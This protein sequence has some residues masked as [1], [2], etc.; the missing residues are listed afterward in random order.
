MA[1]PL[2]PASC[3]PLGRGCALSRRTDVQRA[4]ETRFQ[5]ARAVGSIRQLKHETHDLETQLSEA[6]L[7][8]IQATAL[9]EEVRAT[10]AKWDAER[11]P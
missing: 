11:G 6:E 9:M 3:V 2:H 5:L 4:A 10:L 1:L 7:L 8:V